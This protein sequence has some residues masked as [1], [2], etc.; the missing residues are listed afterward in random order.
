VA[1]VRA[2]SASRST[3]IETLSHMFNNRVE[4][5][6]FSVNEK[7]KL[8]DK[9]LCELKLKNN[10]L[11]SFINRHGKIII[12][13]GQDCIKAGDTVMIVTT[14]FGFVDITDILE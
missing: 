9:P 3:N 12:P 8:T 4:A 6:E 5:I 13:N 2:K 11:I 7:N 14:H 10:T 1:Y